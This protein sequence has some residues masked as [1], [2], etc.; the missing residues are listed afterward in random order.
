VERNQKSC[1]DDGK[2]TERRFLIPFAGGSS[3]EE[4]TTANSSDD[5]FGRL[6]GVQALPDNYIFSLIKN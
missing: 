6:S 2:E 1:E 5:S 4:Q 3:S